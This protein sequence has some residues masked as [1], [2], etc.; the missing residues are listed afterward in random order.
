ML[1]DF[2]RAVITYVLLQLKKQISLIL[3]NMYKIGTDNATL[4]QEVVDDRVVNG[5]K[6]QFYRPISN[7]EQ[8]SVQVG[9]CIKMLKDPA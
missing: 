2:I 4:P 1:G 3:L 9:R 7:S 6:T 8:V 5:M